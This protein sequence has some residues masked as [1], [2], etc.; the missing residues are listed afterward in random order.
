MTL[1]RRL[2]LAQAPLAAALLLVG[3]ASLRTVA[4]LG[5]SSETILKDNYR[6]VLAAQRM[7]DAIDGLDREALLRALG[8]QPVQVAAV[9]RDRFEAEMHVQEG[10]VTEPGEAE[11]TARLRADWKAYRAAEDSQASSREGIPAYLGPLQ[12]TSAAV[13]S[14]IDEVL[15]LNQDAMVRKS[16]Q[17][18]RSAEKL[19]QL[20]IFATAVALGLGL[21]ASFGLTAR[22]VKPLS[23][24]ALAVRRFGEGDVE[25]RARPRGKD[26]IA[27]LASEFNTMADRLEEYRKSS[28]G[29]LIQAQQASQA[30]IDSLPD[31]VIVL[32]V[33]GLVLNRNRAAEGLLRAGAGDDAGEQLHSLDPALRERIEAIRTHVLS[34]RG[35]VVPRGFDE[36]V[37]VELPDGARRLLP[38]ATALYSEE[39]AVTGVTVVLQDVTRLVRFDELKNDLV[40]TVAHEF[41]TPLT[42][43]RMAVHMCAEEAAGPL[44]AAQADLMASARQDCERLQGIVDDILDLSRIQAG[45]IEIH[46][47][48]VDACA[49][50]DRAVKEV[51][52]AARA[53][54]VQAWA[55]VP[56]GPVSVEADPER[57]DVVLGNLLGNAVRHTPAGGSV[58]ARLQATGDGVRVEVEDTGEGIP[59]QYLDR[60]FDR[61]FQVPGPRRGGVGLGLYI[62]R[63]VVRAHGGE[64]GLVSEA[65]KGSTF[66]FTLPAR[67]SAAA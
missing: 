49:L 37:R 67:P 16:N 20:M 7:G 22:I 36:A 4:Y 38:R 39:G 8:N 17:A 29:D 57:I 31:P 13:R 27:S 42:S 53:A 24:L 25:S 9:L 46:A 60:V 2:L 66:W 41:R 15:V 33:D 18:R 51:E 32:D 64:M 6:S 3:A 62:S 43:L 21:V 11:A 50:V 30:A 40:A 58:V 61:F 5:E 26:E 56:L 45:R 59:A 34:G 28:L 65:G 44:T 35:A 47:R 48:S 10:N 55:R 1:R 52:G 12:R 54:G 14:A 63:E 19:L 23:S